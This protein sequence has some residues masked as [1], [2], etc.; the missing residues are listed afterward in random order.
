MRVL[1]EGWHRALALLR[2][3]R[4]EHDLDDEVAFHLAMRE[5]EQ[6]PQGNPPP[7]AG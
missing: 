2:R 5:A 6:S 4:L 3:K 1:I 7:A